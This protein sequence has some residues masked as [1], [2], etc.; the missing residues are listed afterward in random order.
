MYVGNW[1]RDIRTPQPYQNLMLNML[2]ML[3]DFT[4][5]NG[6]THI[7]EGSHD[8]LEREDYTEGRF[9]G[10]AGDVVLFNSA[11]L[12]KAG[13]NSTE[14]S[15]S[16]LTITLTKP[17]YKPQFD[18]CGLGT[19]K[20]YCKDRPFISQVYGFNSLVPTSLEQWYVPKDQ[21]TYKANQG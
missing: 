10:L 13:V 20:K 9:V 4:L 1:H 12:H 6:A 19:V 7:K 11:C 21:R 18:Y 17:F 14:N 15:R 5:E 16:C 2:V 8:A 3:D